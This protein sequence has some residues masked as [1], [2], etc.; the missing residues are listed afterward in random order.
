MLFIVV[1]QNNTTGTPPPNTMAGPTAH[2][3]RGAHSGA[4]PA[5]RKPTHRHSTNAGKRA[6]H[7]A[8]ARK[9]VQCA[10]LCENPSMLNMPAPPMR[11]ALPRKPSVSPPLPDV[12]A[13]SVTVRESSPNSSGTPGGTASLP[14]QTARIVSGNS[15]GMRFASGPLT[16]M[17]VI[18]S[19][20]PPEPA[21]VPTPTAR[22]THQ[23]PAKPVTPTLPVERDARVGIDMHL[24]ADHAVEGGCMH[25]IV[26]LRVPDH[27]SPASAMLLAQPR[28]RLIGYESLQ[29]DETRHIFYH[30]ASVLD[31][32]RSVDGPSEPYVLHGA[33]DQVES[34]MLPCYASLP[35]ADGFYL[36]KGGEFEL[37]FTLSLPI[38]RG[39]RGSYK[40]AHAQVGYLVIAS[41]R[42]KSFGEQHGGVAHCFSPIDLHPYINPTAALASATRPIL[43]RNA[44]PGSSEA[45][46]LVAA[47]HR[48]TWV[49]GQRVYLDISARNNSDTPLEHLS[50]ALVRTERIRRDSGES[51]EET[52]RASE[53][54]DVRSAAPHWWKGIAAHAEHHFS[55]AFMLP[56][57]EVSI[58]HGRHVDVQH[59]LRITVKSA[60][61]AHA[62]LPLRIVSYISI[63]PPPVKRNLAQCAGLFPS[64]LTAPQDPVQMVERVR[65]LETLRSPRATM[66]AS[67]HLVPEPPRARTAQHRRSLDF[68]NHAIRSATARHGSPCGGDEAP[69]GLGIELAGDTSR[70][71]HCAPREPMQGLPMIELPEDAEET[72]SANQSLVLGD[73]TADDVGLVFDEHRENT[74]ENASMS[75]TGIIDAY[76]R[77]NESSIAR[78]DIDNAPPSREA[79]PTIEQNSSTPRIQQDGDTSQNTRRVQPRTL[80]HHRSCGTLAPQSL[81]TT[82]TKNTHS[83]A[84]AAA[85]AP[86]V[87]HSRQSNFFV[88][89]NDSPLKVKAKVSSM[90]E[91]SP[92]EQRLRRTQSSATLRNVAPHAT[93]MNYAVSGTGSNASGERTTKVHDFR[94]RA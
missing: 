47:L 42:V 29:G 45:I 31:G 12:H 59:H 25:G 85:T 51:H 87:L 88:A 38:G 81:P 18:P 8:V 64:A 82:P 69:L 71:P 80:T 26:R 1:Y 74:D 50:I 58:P 5:R 4:P 22:P 84:P 37:P 3:G 21:P 53:S 33:V 11:H 39:A 55:H 23:L 48:H 44:L 56:E 77:T 60:H 89:S 35:D 75:W 28:V 9:R 72:R 20:A 27:T 94:A 6:P 73:E 36:G 78:V 76:D 61:E 46:D 34:Q 40:S 10:P 49:A 30:H 7:A 93:R 90:F 57:S 91:Q 68:I 65:S 83:P 86:R 2:S 24:A 70:E 17:M 14:L 62:D 63:D 13:A 67:G 52:L 32:D 41:V 54:L 16:D 15:V 79:T 19:A 66:S 92:R 43:A